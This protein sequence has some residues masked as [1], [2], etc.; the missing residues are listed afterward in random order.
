MECPTGP[1]LLWSILQQKV[2]LLFNIWFCSTVYYCRV[3]SQILTSLQ[4]FLKIWK[5]KRDGGCFLWNGLPNVCC[6]QEM[7]CCKCGTFQQDI[8]K[9]ITKKENVFEDISCRISIFSC[10]HC[11]FQGAIFGTLLVFDRD[12]T[13][14]YPEKDSHNKYVGTLLNGD[15]WVK[16]TFN[17][18]GI[19][20]ER[21]ARGIRESVNSY[22]E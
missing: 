10:F 8:D 20:R 18:K 2:A 4:G 15:K 22:R 11:L 9:N 12:L 1:V 5:V 14:T 17:I 7:V 13:T 16:D 3:C 19:F 6:S 21:K